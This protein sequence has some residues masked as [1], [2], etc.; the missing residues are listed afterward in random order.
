VVSDEGLEI[1]ALFADPEIDGAGTGFD[2]VEEVVLQ[3][4]EVFKRRV[5]FQARPF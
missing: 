1:L 3:H 5:Y 4:G 2:D